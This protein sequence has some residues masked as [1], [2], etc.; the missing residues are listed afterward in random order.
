MNFST[1]IGK[2]KTFSGAILLIAAAGANALGILPSSMHVDISFTQAVAE[3]LIAVGLG[4]K[5]QLL[6]GLLNKTNG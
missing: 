4:S 1:I 5:L 2:G 3:G 6:I